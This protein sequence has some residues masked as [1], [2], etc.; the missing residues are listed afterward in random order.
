MAAVTLR[1]EPAGQHALKNRSRLEI[2]QSMLTAMPCGKT[3]LLYRANLG[4]TQRDRYVETLGSAGLAVYDQG[5]K[6]W[7][8]TEKGDL[9]V[10]KMEQL[11]DVGK[12]VLADSMRVDD[13]RL[14]LQEFWRRR[15]A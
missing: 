2:F 5:E 3:H 7:V 10:E 9:F 6:V 4:G 11:M 1:K 13:Q 14:R 15:E 12:G 8:R